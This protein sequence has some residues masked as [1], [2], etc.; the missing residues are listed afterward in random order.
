MLNRSF[1]CCSVKERVKKKKLKKIPTYTESVQIF[2][3]FTHILIYFYFF[4]LKGGFSHDGG[5]TSIHVWDL[6]LLSE[7]THVH[8]WRL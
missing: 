3:S 2:Y 6:R 4:S 1:A 8:I 7:W 5:H